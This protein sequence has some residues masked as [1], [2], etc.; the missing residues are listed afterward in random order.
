MVSLDISQAFHQHFDRVPEAVKTA[1]LVTVSGHRAG[2]PVLMKGK[3]AA[4][5]F[6]GLEYF[7]QSSMTLM[8]RQFVQERERSA[9]RMN[10]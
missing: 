5:I 7:Q 10:D 8:A 6:P 4:M 9:S 2:S 1:V 3:P